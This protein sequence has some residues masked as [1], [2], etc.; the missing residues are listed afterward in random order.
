MAITKIPKQPTEVLD[1][2]FDYSAWLVITDEISAATITVPSGITLDSYSFTDTV[3]KIWLSG[4][5]DGETYKIT[6]LV[7]TSAGRKKEK[8]LRIKV[9]DN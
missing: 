2:D 9:K 3:V 1:Y 5:T 7:T 4:G 8:E 6:C